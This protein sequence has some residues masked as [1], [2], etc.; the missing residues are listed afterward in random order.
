MPDFLTTKE[1][2]QLLRI[3]ERKVYDLAASG[4]VPCSKAMGKLLFPRDAVEAWLAKNSSGFDGQKEA[5]PRPDVFLGSHDPLLDWA[6]RES[7][8]G[9]ATYFDGSADGLSRF[10]RREGVAAGL[11]LYDA[12]ADDW[13]TAIVAERCAFM[14]V[15]LIE[16]A[17]RQRGLILNPRLRTSALTI[18]DLMGKRFAPRQRGS[19]TENLFRHLL[20]KSGITLSDLTLTPPARTENDAA[21]MV[22]EDKADATFGLAALA[23]QYRL[24]FTPIIEERFDL[25]IDRRSWFE[26]A[27]QRF[28]SLC[29]SNK[30]AA[31]A[32]DLEGYDLTNFGHVHFNGS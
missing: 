12:A 14:P 20:A 27:L 6:L 28:F 29:H 26:P 21:L 8:S 31:R 4:A 25:L 16:W 2:A 11:H 19:G 32:N 15:V 17:K 7:H 24:S 13:N 9:I 18:A 30:L 10:E 23:A 5:Q 3:K 22:L 1:L